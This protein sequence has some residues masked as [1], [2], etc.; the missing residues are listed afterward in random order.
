MSA[1]VVA[2]EVSR[3]LVGLGLAVWIGG[4]LAGF[5]AVRLADEK[6]GAAAEILARELLEQLD[7]AKFIVAGG[8]LL[9]VLLEV[10]TAGSQLPSRRILRDGILFILI[11][12]HVYS[13]MV[14]QPRLRYYRGMIE[15]T[16]ASGPEAGGPWQAKCRLQ[17]RR[18]AR[19]SALG[20]ALAA[21]ALV[22]G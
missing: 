7:K 19:V 2:I 17:E 21:A 13:V 20:L 5:G 18:V 22:V 14:V 11:A 16:S 12:S 8:L 4:T 3:V 1:E 10:Q 15:G 6:P 9:G